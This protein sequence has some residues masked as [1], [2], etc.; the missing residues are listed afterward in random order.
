M[1]FF[2]V[3]LYFISFFVL[4]EK[5][6]TSPETDSACS[7]SKLEIY[8]FGNSNTNNTGSLIPE[9]THLF[10][11]ENGPHLCAHAADYPPLYLPPRPCEVMNKFF[12]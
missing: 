12:I 9:P 11:G 1:H 2:Q 3:W 4:V 5:R 6:T 8:D 7:V 10:C